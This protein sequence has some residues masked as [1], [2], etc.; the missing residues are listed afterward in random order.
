MWLLLSAPQ[1]YCNSTTAAD[2][3]RHPEGAGNLNRTYDCKRPVLRHGRVST[4]AE[5]RTPPLCCGCVANVG[6]LSIL[7]SVDFTVEETQMA[8]Y[9]QTVNNMFQTSRG[10]PSTA[11]IFQGWLG[12]TKQS[13]PTDF[14]ISGSVHGV[15]FGVLPLL[16]LCRFMEVAARIRRCAC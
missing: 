12:S 4:G 1:G 8:L 15:G 7:K 10:V 9:S 14:A 6:K 5:H 13:A 2:L 11:H 3:A 16:I